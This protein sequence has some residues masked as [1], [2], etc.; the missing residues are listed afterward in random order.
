M[1]AAAPMSALVAMA[2]CGSTGND[3]APFLGTGDGG[4]D[5]GGSSSGTSGSGDSGRD[6]PRVGPDGAPV[7]AGPDVVFDAPPPVGA[8]RVTL[9]LPDGKWHRVSA[10]AGGTNEDISTP[11]DAVSPGSDS[12]LGSSK[13][14]DWI[15][16]SSS[17]FSCAGG[18]CLELF[19]GA[20]SSGSE[21]K[22]AGHSADLAEARPAVAAGGGV[23]VYPSKGGPHSV[24]LYAVTKAA[25]AWS[26]PVLLT[27]ASSFAFHHDASIAPDGTR[28]VFDCGADLYAQPPTSLCEVA[29]DGT[30]FVELLSPSDGPD[31][32]PSHALHHPDYTPQGDV[33]FEADWPS[34]TVWKLPRGTKSA[35]RLSGPTETDDNSPCVLPDGHVASL[36]L[37]RPGN[38]G[39]A[40]ELKIMNA[41]GG[42]SVMVLTGSDIVDIGI[43]CGN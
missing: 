9:R 2:A 34:E 26:A 25:G 15:V 17:R 43:S 21:V 8:G 18:S 4:G 42:G 19:A 39:N 27:G 6:G 5:G 3:A 33:V 24:D 32:G 14:G 12:F 41:N 11:M 36:W 7:D 16:A 13:D 37:G 1:R 10:K 38:T 35:V 40:H 28:V 31:H 22:P 30:G 23:I 29:T 20:L